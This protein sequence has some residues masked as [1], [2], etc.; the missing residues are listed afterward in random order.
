MTTFQATA[1]EFYKA[2]AQRERHESD[3]GGRDV[4]F[5]CLAD[6]SPEWMR[7]AIQ[8][9][10]F[11]G[12]LPDDWIYEQCRAIAGSLEERESVDCD[13]QH[14]ICDG[15]VDIYTGALTSWLEQHTGNAG[16]VDE[17]MA[18]GLCDE[19]ATIAQR[20][21]SAQYM[22]L[23]YICGALVSAIESEAEE[24]DAGAGCYSEQT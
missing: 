9:A 7:D 14:E 15:L 16:L 4:R 8:S 2:F 5:W 20:I 21:Q 1:H 10:H 24:R 3:E 6:G 17:A 23:T 13:D 11:D 18:E 19:S 12:R 22:A